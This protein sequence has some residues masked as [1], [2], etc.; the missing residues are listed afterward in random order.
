MDEIVDVLADIVVVEIARVLRLPAKEVDHHRKLADIGMDSLMMLE[1]RMIVENSLQIE[2]PMMSL[3]SGI[4]P[5]EIARKVAPLIAGHVQQ[6]SSSATTA[7]TSRPASA[8]GENSN[9]VQN[10]TEDRIVSRVLQM[11]RSS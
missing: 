7:A 11:D 1:L 6:N 5:A 3:S 2:L 10:L 4:T 9:D 8:D